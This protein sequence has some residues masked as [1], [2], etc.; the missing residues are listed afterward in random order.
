MLYS[1][2]RLRVPSFEQTYAILFFI[3]LRIHIGNV[4]FHICFCSV[5]LFFFYSFSLLPYIG[6]TPSRFLHVTRTGVHGSSM[7]STQILWASYLFCNI[8]WW[9][10]RRR[11]RWMAEPFGLT[12]YTALA[13]STI[14]TAMCVGKCP[15]YQRHWMTVN[16]SH[17]SKHSMQHSGKKNDDSET[18]I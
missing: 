3:S 2:T 13:Y 15:K 5:F 7:C 6:S 4:L 1:L 12:L 14:S 8:V 18:V 11:G 16:I 17:P 9:Q 10:W